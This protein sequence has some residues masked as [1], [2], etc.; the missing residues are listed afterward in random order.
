MK[1]R[2]L[3]LFLIVSFRIYAQSESDIILIEQKVASC[4]A[5]LPSYKRII[6][7]DSTQTGID[8]QETVYY[9]N[10]KNQI[11]FIQETYYSETGKTIIRN[12]ID[13]DSPYYI[14]KEYYTSRAES[15]M[16]NPDTGK[17]DKK[18]EHIYFKDSRI[19]KRIL[20]KKTI[21]KYDKSSAVLENN[22]IEHI[23]S[24]IAMF[25]QSGK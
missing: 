1:F 14:Y 24:M 2:F 4:N 7:T 13:N 6:L 5:A 15:N 25:E 19:I 10:D 21:K 3:F 17:W 18:E 23:N 11:K 9:Y 22:I 16:A 12:Y 20:D 8:R